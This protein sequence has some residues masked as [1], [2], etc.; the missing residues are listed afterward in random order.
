MV[1]KKSSAKSMVRTKR[2]CINMLF[3]NSQLF[4]LDNN[5]LFNCFLFI[6]G[7]TRNWK[8]ERWLPQQHHAENTL[9]WLQRNW[10]T[11]FQPVLQVCNLLVLRWAINCYMYILVNRSQ[12]TVSACIAGLWC[13]VMLFPNSNSLLKK[14][15]NNNNEFSFN[16]HCITHRPPCDIQLYI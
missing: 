1:N 12:V 14:T 8:G 6:S 3:L 10:S 15:N 13:S 16:I 5:S 2:T 4:F 9:F 7:L 11:Y